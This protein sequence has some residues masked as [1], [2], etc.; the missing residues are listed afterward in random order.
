MPT[1]LLGSLLSS[2]LLLAFVAWA[3]GRPQTDAPLVPRTGWGWFLFLFSPASYALHSHHTEG[4]FLLLSFG[5]LVRAVF[6]AHLRRHGKRLFLVHDL[7][8]QQNEI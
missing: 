1:P 6:R 3:S 7:F 8:A 2:G 5:A 4:R